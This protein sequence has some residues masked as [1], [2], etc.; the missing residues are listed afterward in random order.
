MG[1]TVRSGWYTLRIG[2]GVIRHP[3]DLKL[4]MNSMITMAPGHP[5]Q[6]FCEITVQYAK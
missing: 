1:A 6:S 5:H 4:S 2:S 3:D